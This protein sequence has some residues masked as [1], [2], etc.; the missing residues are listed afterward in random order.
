MMGCVFAISA[1]FYT[2]SQ[3]LPTNYRCVRAIKERGSTLQ[4]S[5]N[6][7]VAEDNEIDTVHCPEQTQD[8][9][10]ED[11]VESYKSKEAEQDILRKNFEETTESQEQA[12]EPELQGAEMVESKQKSDDMD[13]KSSNLDTTLTTTELALTTRETR[14]ARLHGAIPRLEENKLSLEKEVKNLRADILYQAD[15]HEKNLAALEAQF[16]IEYG[17]VKGEMETLGKANQVLC[18]NVAQANAAVEGLKMQMETVA[19]TAEAM[20]LDLMSKLEDEQAEY[21]KLEDDRDYLQED[22]DALSKE[23][24]GLKEDRHALQQERDELARR[25]SSLEDRNVESR[26]SLADCSPQLISITEEKAELE[27]ETDE[28]TKL[29]EVKDHPKNTAEPERVDALIDHMQSREDEVLGSTCN[30]TGAGS[31]AYDS[32]T[33]SGEEWPQNNQET[34]GHGVN[35]GGQAGL[36]FRDSGYVDDNR[37]FDKHYQSGKRL[38]TAF[39][40]KVEE[41]LQVLTEGTETSTTPHVKTTLFTLVKDLEDTLSQMPLAKEDDYQGDDTLID[42]TSGQLTSDVAVDDHSCPGE[43]PTRGNEAPSEDYDDTFAQHLQDP[44][45]FSDVVGEDHVLQQTLPLK[46]PSV[47]TLDKAQRTVS[48]ELQDQTTKPKMTRW[49]KVSH[50]S[51]SLMG[52]LHNSATP[53][54]HG[55]R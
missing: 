32:G 7:A 42:D 52:G 6:D 25:L 51:R 38:L 19:E 14:A 9:D 17:V 39:R 21:N 26:Q 28:W 31:T 3:A 35:V 41:I 22:N 1:G 8:S 15:E 43:K 48:D 11:S 55:K 13:Y 54:D 46:P 20:N 53:G 30:G 4:K 12:I 37:P 50:K 44:Y 47:A 40:E 34:Y 49:K 10:I 33:S 24:E 45:S 2:N 16:L 23:I 36:V 18:G 5:G 27:H 29:T